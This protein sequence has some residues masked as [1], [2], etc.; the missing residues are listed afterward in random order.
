MDFFTFTFTLLLCFWIIQP[1]FLRIKQVI[2]NFWLGIFM[3]VTH[4][5]KIV[6]LLQ[7]SE[8][9][10]TCCRLMQ[11]DPTFMS[12]PTRFE[13]WVITNLM[14]SFL[15]YLFMPL[16]VSSSKCS[17]SGGPNCINTSSCITHSGEWLSVCQVGHYPELHQDAQS[18][19]YKIPTWIFALELWMIA[20]DDLQ[21]NRRIMCYC[22]A[23]YLKYLII[24]YHSDKPGPR[25]HP[26]KISGTRQ[27]PLDTFEVHNIKDIERI[28]L[29]FAL[30]YSCL[31]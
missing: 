19:K 15:M 13:F 6:S 18:T 8:N 28:Y 9:F 22:C 26:P 3:N 30:L 10:V 31:T 23:G 12:W 20:L 24:S 7:K 21:K 17:S 16:H 25:I 14:H 5:L 27:W 1:P 11:S 2:V 4:T 29:L